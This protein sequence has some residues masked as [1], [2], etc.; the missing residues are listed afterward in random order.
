M[1]D[2]TCGLPDSPNDID[3]I[4]PWCPL[5]GSAVRDGRRMGDPRMI[6][7]TDRVQ[8]LIS[9]PSIFELAGGS[10]VGR[11]HRVVPK[12]N[13]DAWYITTQDECFVGVVCDG[14]GSGNFTE[15]GARIGASIIAKSMLRRAVFYH[16]SWYYVPGLLGEVA[17]DLLSTVHTLASAMAEDPDY[18]HDVI[19]DYFLFTISGVVCDGERIAFFGLGDGVFM[20]N[21]E[22]VSNPQYPGNAPPYLAYNLLGENRK[23]GW[24]TERLPV[25][26]VESFLVGCDGTRDL[27]RAC[28]EDRTL[29]GMDLPVG[30]VSQFWETD[31]FFSNRAALSRRLKLIGRDW[32]ARDPEHG[33]LADDTT[34]IVGRRR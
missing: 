3:P 29:P 11:D 34:I 1:P 9:T 6:E 22:V 18:Y 28:A 10:V 4:D 16:P 20:I 26:R 14:C 21:G 30:D 8:R 25:E 32:P 2:C 24:E 7:D 33:L 13:Q 12:N 17:I 5:H 23:L 27:M 31:A 15:T 19:L